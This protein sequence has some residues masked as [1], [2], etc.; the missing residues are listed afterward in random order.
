[1][2]WLLLG[3]WLA[4]ILF[5]HFRG[6]VRLPLARQL[7]DHSILLAP[8][9]ALLV[10][11]SKVPTTP[12]LPI[13]HVPELKILEDHWETIRDEA[14]H[15]STLQAIKA[16]ELHNDI[17]FNSFFKY[18][19]K[20]FY[21]KWYDA[22][23]PS[24]VRLC[25]KTVALLNQIPCIKAAM[26]AE[27]PPGGQLNPHRDPFAGSLRYHLGL[28]TPNHDQCYIDVD[29]QRYSWRDGKSVIF[30]ETYVHEAYNRT[31]ENRIILFCD[32]ERPLKWAW[33][34]SVNRWLGRVLISAASSP[35]DDGSDQT[36]LINKLTQ[37]HW[38]V[39]QKRRTFKK[40]NRTLYKAT[41]FG[42]IALAIYLFL[43]V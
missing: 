3:A 6:K 36:G 9:N 20:R 23:H 29:G 21:L 17:G 25:P 41:K 14:V 22:K 18:G 34:R 7:L 37:Y 35:N 16:P 26:F 32:I 5:T 4:A 27:L 39:D 12:Y 40:A 33:A 24:A 8:I 11:N 42:L 30:D 13:D 31:L 1:M 10:L 19:W 28:V 2:K 43:S 38:Q 15:L